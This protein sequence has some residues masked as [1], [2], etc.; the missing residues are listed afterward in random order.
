MTQA[1]NN[2]KEDANSVSLFTLRC[3]QS[4]VWVVLQPQLAASRGESTM[5]M[6]D[7]PHYL[8]AST[9]RLQH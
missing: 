1:T 4:V 7:T 2:W 5:L 6:S 9:I 3:K 8:P